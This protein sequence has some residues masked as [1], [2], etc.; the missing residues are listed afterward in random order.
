MRVG[1][2]AKHVP[3]R[4]DDRCGDE[5]RSLAAL[6]R[7]LV[8]PSAHGQQLLQHRRQ[9]VDVP[10]EHRASGARR[11]IVRRV[12]AVDGA[13]SSAGIPV[14]PQ[15]GRKGGW[16]LLGGARTDLSGLTASE[17][18]AL[19]LLVGPAAAIAPDAKAALRKLVRALPGTFRADAE[20]AAS[21]IVIDPARW[22]ENDRERPALVMSLQAAVV[23]RRKVRL[24]YVNRARVR[25]AAP[26]ALDI[27]R[28]LAGWGALLEVA[29]SEPVRAELARIG[30][31]LADRYSPS[32]AR[33]PDFTP[34]V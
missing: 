28:H 25:L 30:R 5:S 29:E 23:Q 27:A 15:P 12:P 17:A 34:G 33:Q 20:A 21:A 8:F 1:H 16:S 24:G 2:D 4:V 19:F 26:T 9:I 6:G 10:V 3:E 31:E 32:P 22:G 11:H 7:L 13:L 18:Q 14:Y